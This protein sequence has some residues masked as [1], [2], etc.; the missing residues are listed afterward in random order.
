[1]KQQP[2]L[3][4]P[5]AEV[6]RVGMR[7]PEFTPAD[8]ELWFSIVDRSFLATGITVDATKF[9]YALIMV[10]LKNIRLVDQLTNLTAAGCC[11]QC[12]V[13]S[14]KTVNGTTPYHELL[15]HYSE[16]TRSE[17]RPSE[18]KH[19]TKHY[20][21]TTPGPPVV[22]RPRRLA[23]ERSAKKEFEKMMEAGIARPSRS[24]WASP[25]HLMQ[26]KNEE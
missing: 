25:L 4:V 18:I 21:E 2:I 9:G 24:S 22:C 12:S 7:M 6:S 26:K 14:V 23:L 3:F 5:G 20:I 10:D 19:D 15:T 13:P 16:I 11:A 8:P 17:G 1:M